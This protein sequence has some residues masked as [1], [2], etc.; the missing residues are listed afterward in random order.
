MFRQSHL[1]WQIL[2]LLRIVSPSTE[3]QYEFELEDDH[4]ITKCLDDPKGFKD[5]NGLFDLS[6][7]SFELGEEGVVVGGNL[8]SVWDVEPTDRIEFRTSTF[9]WERGFWQPTILNVVSP[10][11]CKT[12]YDEKQ[13]W[14]SIITK[15]VINKEEVKDKCVTHKGTVLVVEPYLIN[16]HFGAGMVLPS[17]RHRTINTMTAFDL[18]NVTRPNPICFEII[19]Q[20]FKI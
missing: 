18:N 14:Y 3:I 8:T 5:M 9:Y 13:L 1:T 12:M 20:F 19:G 7:L 4:V 6:N 2:I 15:Y 10:D 17:G 11:F 16:I